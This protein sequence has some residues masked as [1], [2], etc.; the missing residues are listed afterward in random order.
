MRA[1]AD[2]FYASELEPWSRYLT[3]T[4][5]QDPG[6][7]PLAEL[8]TLAHARNIEVH[9]WFNPYRASLDRR[10]ANAAGHVATAHPDWVVSY[11]TH[12]WMD[13]GR[14]EVRAHTVAVV[15][16]VVSRYDVDGVHFDDYF[17]P[18]PNGATFPDDATFGAYRA[19]GG[20][21]PREA[22]RE[23]NV[24]ALVRD[25]SAAVRETRAGVVFG[26]SPFGIYRPGQPEGIRGMD[27]VAS[28]H[29]DPL[30][31]AREG[32]VDYLAPQLYWPTT[33]K[34][35]AH[36]P[37]MRWW[38]EQT[39]GHC[40]LYVG[41][42]LSQI[43]VTPAWTV[44][45]LAAQRALA[46]EHPGVHGN[47]WFSARPLIEDREDVRAWMREQYATP[48]LP[49]VRHDH[50]LPA[51]TVELDDGALCME[52]AAADSL[53]AYVVYDERG[54]VFAVAPVGSHEHV[55]VPAGT[56]AISAVD[57]GGAES[58]AVVQIVP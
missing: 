22:W 45:E 56:W 41:N 2:A 21:L 38:A 46:V 5:G 58:P 10:R 36:E 20:E 4:Q 8:I 27:Q 30:H 29:A 13:P 57:R 53:R 40:R 7:D 9:A 6:Y 33:Q 37:L 49:P 50:D 1:E 18:Y 15:R 14:P 19:Q 39:G 25:V 47:I 52:H 11:G 3:G 51:P 54:E 12:L 16:D 32:W 24:N 17:Y 34:A 31:W 28:L 35:Q 23:S 44:E 43:G 42:Y 55:A 26:I 48:A